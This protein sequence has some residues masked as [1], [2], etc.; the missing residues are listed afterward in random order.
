M[1]LDSYGSDIYSNKLISFTGRAS[2]AYKD[3]YLLTATARYDGSSRFG[4]NNKW[5]LFP[6]VGVAWRA[7]EEAFLKDNNVVSDL[8]IRMSYGVTGNQEIGNYQSLAR[9]STS[10]SYSYTDGTS[11]LTGYAESVGNKDLKWERTTQIDLGFDL[12]L[13]Q[14]LNINFDYYTRTTKDL[15]YEVP[16]PSSSGYSTVMSN[17]GEVGNKGF[18]ITV[19]GDIFKNKD[20]KIDA[21]VNFTYNKNEIKSLYGDVTRIA[22]SAGNSGLARILEVGYPV[23]SVWGRKSLG[24]IKTEE[25][26]EWYKENVPT[27]GATAQLGDEMFADLDGNGTIDDDDFICYG[28]VEPKYYYGFNLGVQYKNFKLNVYGQGAFKYA[29]IL[30]QENSKA[31]DSSLNLGYANVGSY[32]LYA[33]NQ[34]AGTNYIPSKSAYDDMWSESNPNG[35]HPRIGSVGYLS[36][37]TNADWHYF[38]LKN[39]QLS[40]D[41]TSL[42]KIKTIKQ[43]TLNVNLQNFFTKSKTNGYN[44]ENGDISNPWAKVIMFGI[45]AKF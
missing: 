16:I 28:S 4:K 19:G 12:T 29:S 44:P 35:N 23:N 40:Y 11:A 34:I 36:D 6:S 31:G 15:L 18:E 22:E 38:I 8:K 26:L 2:Y 5:G 14:R 33:D 32:L 7:T 24:I 42:I 10:T 27:T 21:S 13:W 43:L 45:N 30:G 37:R 17:V 1:T 20:W 39:I 41:F 25:Q 9:L 3:K